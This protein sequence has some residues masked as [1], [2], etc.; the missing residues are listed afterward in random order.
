MSSPYRGYVFLLVCVLALGAFVSVRPREPRFEP[1][2]APVAGVIYAAPLE[3]V[4]THV[5]RNGET[6]SGLLSAARITG[7]ELSAL[8][9]ALM[10]HENPRRLTAGSEVTVRRWAYDGSPRYID[11]RVD[12]DRTVRLARGSLGWKGETRV[13][14]TRVDTITVSGTIAAGSALYHAIVQ[15]ENLELPP[16]ERIALVSELADVYGYKLDFTRE[17]QPGDSYRL[18][19]EREARPDGSSRRR[20]I[21]VAEIDTRGVNYSAIHFQADEI[22]SGYYDREGKSLRLA[23]RRYPLD[24]VRVT[25]AFNWQR[26]HPVLGVYRAH[27]GTDFGAPTGTPVRATGDGTIQ[28]AAR[29]GGY[30]NVIRIRHHGGYTT[31]YAH[32][33]R[34]AA[35]VRPGTRVEQGEVIGYVGATGLATGPHLHYELRRDGQPLDARTARL[36]GHPPIPRQLMASFE[37]VRDERLGLLETDTG[38][39]F[40]STAR[41]SM[42][43]GSP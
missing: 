3:S 12:A 33:S 23:F 32:L 21:L 25:S 30:G 36:P 9:M 34:F 6:L 4:E 15:H 26:Y 8:I 1:D 43:A 39:V 27:L 29:D 13:T 41:R 10:E 7:S 20:R 11:L 17:I 31:L 18:V 5:L 2:D 24:F 35:H 14:P 37:Q 16:A 22:G 40:A 42:F 38:P 28:F 19:Y